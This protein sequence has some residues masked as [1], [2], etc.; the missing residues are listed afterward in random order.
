MLADEATPP[1]FPFDVRDSSSPRP[2]GAAEPG[3][4]R[5]LESSD[6]W[7]DI[8][9]FDDYPPLGHSAQLGQHVAA[10]RRVHQMKKSNADDGRDALGTNGEPVR[11]R[12]EKRKLRPWRPN[13]AS[14]HCQHGRR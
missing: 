10:F 13:L 5:A 6:R 11:I 7:I 14:C 8:A 3:E 9:V 1:Q 12:P 2:L 4:D